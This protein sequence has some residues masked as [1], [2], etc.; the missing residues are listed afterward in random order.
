M[1][2][3][4]SVLLSECVRHCSTVFGF[5]EQALRRSVDDGVNNGKMPALFLTNA[6]TRHS[7]LP[8][9]K[10]V[11]GADH[12][13]DKSKY[14]LLS[15]LCTRVRFCTNDGTVLFSGVRLFSNWSGRGGGRDEYCNVVNYNC[16][17]TK[18]VFMNFF[19][20]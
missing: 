10:S 4:W 18:T 9:G 19:Y 16:V 15:A 6:C 17:T 11:F 20:A 2:L 13:T 1:G 8:L 14:V 3:P 12:H 5:A 7:R